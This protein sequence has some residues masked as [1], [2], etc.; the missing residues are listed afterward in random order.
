MNNI[1]KDIR[2]ISFQMFHFDVP[3]EIVG[4][5]ENQRT[6]RTTVLVGVM[7]FHVFPYVRY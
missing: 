1:L 5:R 6:V 7:R 2:A 3:L 4:P